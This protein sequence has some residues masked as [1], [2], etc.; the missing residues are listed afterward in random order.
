M[1]G[2]RYMLNGAMVPEAAYVVSGEDAGLLRGRAVFETLR[3]FNG[4][5]FRGPQHV[6]RLLGS[7]EA[8]GI[9]T[10][11][12]AALLGEL[13]M[14]VNGYSAPAKVNIVLTGG[15]ERLVRVG[16]LDRSRQGAPIR[17]ATRTWEPPPWLDGRSKHCSRALNEAAVRHA[18]VDE[19]FW[20]GRDGS[21]T[22][23]TRSNVFAVVDGE[24]LTPPDDGRILAGVTRSALMEAA[25][26]IDL[27]VREALLRPDTA[28]EELYASS[29][30]KDL[31]P[32]VEL[33][34]RVLT[35]LGPVGARLQAAFAALVARECPPA[36]GP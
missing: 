7:A 32:V 23:A 29:T 17:V 13:H 30:L 22:E 36:N 25:S 8:L 31:A 1:T 16:P 33:D 9:D 20:L 4:Q 5:L 21:I 14:A 34:G 11:G 27:S 19:V 10:P 28:F 6:R 18:G 24:L 15:G 2:N 35:G 12:E 26:D 3:T